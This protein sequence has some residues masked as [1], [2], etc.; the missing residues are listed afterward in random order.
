MQD[1]NVQVHITA[2]PILD[3]DTQPRI[4]FGFAGSTFSQCVFLEAPFDPTTAMQNADAFYKAYLEAC[5]AAVKAWNQ[6]Q[7]DMAN[8]LLSD[9]ESDVTPEAA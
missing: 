6:R 1:N 9:T 5:G 2:A 8:E 7:V 3:G 4:I